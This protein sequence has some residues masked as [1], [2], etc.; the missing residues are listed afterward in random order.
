M[1]VRSGFL[2]EENKYYPVLPTKKKLGIAGNLN[3]NQLM[4][5]NSSHS[6]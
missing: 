1:G 5:K 6:S 2:I 4:V 3:Q